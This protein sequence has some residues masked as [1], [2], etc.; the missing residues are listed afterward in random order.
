MEYQNDYEIDKNGEEDKEDFDL[1]NAIPVGQFREIKNERKFKKIQYTDEEY[2]E[3]LGNDDDFEKE[4]IS[5]K[6]SYVYEDIKAHVF[7]LVEKA[8]NMDSIKIVLELCEKIENQM[9]EVRV[10]YGFSEELLKE[11]EERNL[12]DPV[13]DKLRSEMEDIKKISGY[14]FD[15]AVKQLA[16]RKVVEIGKE[17]IK[18]TA[19]LGYNMIGA[20]VMK[21][22]K[23]KRIKGIKK[24]EKESK[25]FKEK[26]SNI[27]Q[28]RKKDYIPNEEEIEQYENI[29]RNC[30][31]NG[32]AHGNSRVYIDDFE[33]NF[34]YIDADE[35]EEYVD[36][37]AKFIEENNEK[38]KKD[39]F[40]KRTIR[41]VKNFITKVGK[42]FVWIKDKESRQV[43]KNK[44]K[45]RIKSS[46]SYKQAVKLEKDVIDGIK[47]SVTR[48]GIVKNDIKSGMENVAIYA[49][50]TAQDAATKV[51][52]N[53]EQARDRYNK[54]KNDKLILALKKGKNFSEEQLK[55]I[56]IFIKENGVKEKEVKQP[57][58]GINKNPVSFDR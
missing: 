10:L 26:G 15:R 18:G 5:D 3:N 43:F 2:L 22:A 38:V 17:T 24:L 14:D 40:V 19:N 58:K 16:G 12:T 36:L 28:R 34:E 6:L 29:T 25:K 9:D 13:I 49:K 11:L 20:L 23:A 21:R 52:T 31:K 53:Y 37:E 7:D 45:E 4:T 50:S 55:A 48:A 44:Q 30:P 41:G 56:D 8:K 1:R 42:K 51:K 27:N 32:R 39:N 57:Q 35:Y 46:N 33:E 54:R 47:L